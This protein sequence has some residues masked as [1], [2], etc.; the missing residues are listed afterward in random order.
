MIPQKQTIL[1]DPANGKHGN[2]M[3][4]VLASLLHIPVETVP[5]FIHP[6]TWVKDLNDWLRPKGLAYCMVENFDCFMKAY[7]IQELYHELSGNTSRSVDVIHA[8]VAKDGEQIFDPHP[9]DSGLTKIT[10]YGFFIALRPWLAVN[11][12]RLVGQSM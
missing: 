8:V 10:C 3:S 11:E 9:D 2:C 7:G 5:L 12:Q 4:A 1:H 6:D